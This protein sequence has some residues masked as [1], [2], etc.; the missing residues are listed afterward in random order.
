M[1]KRKFPKTKPLTGNLTTSTQKLSKSSTSSIETPT[2]ST[3][4]RND[5]IDNSPPSPSFLDE[6]PELPLEKKRKTIEISPAKSDFSE[7]FFE[8]QSLPFLKQI[9]LSCG[10]HLKSD[11]NILC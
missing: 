3:I 10:L 8:N 11:Q 2:V 6:M 4:S 7:P 5:S 9:L 1:Y